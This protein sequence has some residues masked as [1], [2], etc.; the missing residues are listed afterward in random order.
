M[1]ALSNY[2]LHLSYDIIMPFAAGSGISG[3]I[4]IIDAFIKE[5]A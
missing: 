4:M 3:G 1:L 5:L 2:F